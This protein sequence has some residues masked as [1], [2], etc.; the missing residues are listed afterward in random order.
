MAQGII[1]YNQNKNKNL[2]K[3]DTYFNIVCTISYLIVAITEDDA[4]DDF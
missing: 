1:T 4:M 2:R 3:A